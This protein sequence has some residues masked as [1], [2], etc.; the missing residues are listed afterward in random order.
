MTNKILLI[1]SAFIIFCKPNQVTGQTITTLAGTGT[2]SYSGD[3]SAAV[4]AGLNN[5]YDMIADA[6]GNVYI[7]DYGNN[8]IRKVAPSGTITTIAGNGA[9]GFY[10]DGGQATSAAIRSPK[11]ITMDP[12]GNIVFSDCGNNRIR[13]VNMTTGIIT[14]IV[15]SGGTSGFSGDGG[16][17]TAAQT[18]FPDGLTY[19]MSGN[20]YFAD[21]TNCRVRKVDPSGVINTIA[22]GTVCWVGG[23]G[24]PASASTLQ[25]PSDVV[26]D[27][28]GNI[29]IADEGANRVRKINT[30]GIITTIS[31]SAVLGYTGDGGPS[32]AAKLYYPHALCTDA[33]GNVYLTDQYNNVVRKINSVTGII[34]TIAGNGYGAGTGS[35]GFSG[36][37]GL[38][39]AA[40]LFLP[41][42][43]CVVSSTGMIYIADQQ[44]NRVRVIS[45]LHKPYFANGGTQY[46]NICQ[47]SSPVNID[48]VL[49]ADDIDV[50]QTEIWSLV[51]APAH[52]AIVVGYT[53][54]STGATMLPSGLIYSPFSSFYGLDTFRVQIYD[55]TFYDTTTVYVSATSTTPGTIYGTNT[56]CPGDATTLTDSVAGGVWGSTNT[57]IAT[58]SSSGLVTAV[59][60]G[61]D[62]ITY[63]VTNICGT[64]V[65]RFPVLVQSYA[66]CHTAVTEPEAALPDDIAIY[67]NPNNGRFSM[68]FTTGADEEVT[69]II[70]NTLGAKVSEVKGKVNRLPEFN[71]N[72]PPGVYIVTAF[73]PH[74]KFKTMR[75]TIR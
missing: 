68:H 51:T 29:F 1:L 40:Q 21:A 10:G 59:A 32:S 13:K 19:D 15:N 57:T 6:A 41:T 17:A 18:G 44:N 24:G 46:L 20:L 63:T 27:G 38:A 36:D 30:S 11:G 42:G 65:A 49:A 37:G 12:S 70:S 43:V 5:P 47:T 53:A 34:T 69:V 28:S 61:N 26:V 72:Q 60:P 35:G 14:T 55:G 62:T 67:P 33:S 45:T 4:A 54:T 2:P 58:V 74:Y 48:T 50:G 39:T 71:L 8:R 64:T 23:D 3:G 22:G 16:P 75:V 9:S 73:T 66:I 52:G 31:G 56:L 25:G 7:S